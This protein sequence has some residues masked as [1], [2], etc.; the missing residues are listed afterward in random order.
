MSAMLRFLAVTITLSLGS[1]VVYQ[2]VPM[3]MTTQER[4]D[5]SWGAAYG[6]IADQGMTITAQDRGAGVIRGERSGITLTATLQTLPDGSIRVGFNS[7][8]ATDTDPG[9][10]RRVSESYDRRM[11]R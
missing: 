8:G 11:G 10:I 9:L 2:P 1:C 7:S 3:P 5:R 4:L 6:A